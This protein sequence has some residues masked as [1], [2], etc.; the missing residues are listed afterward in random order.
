MFLRKILFFSLAS[1]VM[2][3]CNES[4]KTDETALIKGKLNNAA[5]TA[6]YFQRVSE[7]GEQIL[8]S[9]KT[10]DKG[11][12]SLKNKAD[13]TDYYLLRTGN[14]IAYLILSGGENLEIEGDASNL[15][16]TYKVKGSKDTE[17]IIDLKRFDMNLRDSLNTVYTTARAKDPQ[18]VN[19]I[20]MSLNKVYSERMNA[21]AMDFIQKNM[22]SFAVLSATNRQF[23]DQEKNAELMKK[24][25]QTLKT[26][27]PENK[28]VS[29]FGILVDRLN[30]MPVGSAAPD[31]KIADANGK[32]ISLSQLKGKVVLVD[33]W[34]SW[35][36]PCRAE[37]PN[38]VS[39]YNDFHSKGF[40]ILGVSLD[41]NK[42]AWLD[43]V[44]KDKLSWLHGCE[45]KRWNSEIA[46]Q[47]GVEAIP[48]SVLVDKEG[49]IV[50]KGLRAEELR[51]ILTSMFSAI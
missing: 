13:K 14:Q 24:V 23:I 22:E 12:F 7:N 35:C 3:S 8:D 38:V 25:E 36:G 48:Y 46:K 20:G 30:K 27:Y 11:E 26:K 47:Y 45:L 2:F 51:P 21:F 1:I 4:K 10:N 15:D 39:M 41:E 18:H 19:E 44:K 42:E 49:K 40:E 5:N 29:E 33:F 37:N 17:L 31:F 6:I 9:T 28:Y 50:A 43:A 16:A 34:A 32:E